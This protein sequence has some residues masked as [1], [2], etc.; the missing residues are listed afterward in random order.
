[1]P[2][3]FEETELD[4]TIAAVAVGNRLVLDSSGTSIGRHITKNPMALLIGPEGG[5]EPAELQ[6]ITAAGWIPIAIAD[7]ILR[8]ETAIITSVGV[9]RAL[10]I[11]G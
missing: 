10:Q 1:M 3:V 2:E 6:R 7:T 11:G 4:E 9:V 5:I 8:F